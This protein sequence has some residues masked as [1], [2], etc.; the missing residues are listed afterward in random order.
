M[1]S[2]IPFGPAF[3]LSAI[4]MPTPRSRCPAPMR[5]SALHQSA[6]NC[7]HRPTGLVVQPTEQESR[8]TG[9]AARGQGRII[10]SSGNQ[11]RHH[12][13]FPY[14]IQSRRRG[15]IFIR[16]ASISYFLLTVVQTAK[17]K[18]SVLAMLCA[19]S[20]GNHKKTCSSQRISYAVVARSS[21]PAMV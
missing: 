6:S 1:R 18:R 12:Y 3:L 2:L 16:S 17:H 15:R 21:R 19:K 9:H 11:K 7:Q 8:P 10:Q 14:L 13:N 20:N 4:L 5:E